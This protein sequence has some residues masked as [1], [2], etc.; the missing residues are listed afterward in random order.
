M[1]INTH[2]K[3]CV[4]ICIY[5]YVY[6]YT[7]RERDFRGWYAPPITPSPSTVIVVKLF[8]EFQVPPVKV[9]D[10]NHCL[11]FRVAVILITAPHYHV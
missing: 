10:S 1:Y 7:T 6:V 8:E 4:C 2:D 11:V 9:A 5:I 3:E